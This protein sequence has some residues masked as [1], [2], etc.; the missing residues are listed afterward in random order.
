[1]SLRPDGSY[2][3]DKCDTDVDNGGV[4]AAVTIIGTD[5]DDPG[6]MRVPLHLCL[7]RDVDTNGNGQTEH[8]P[9]CRD[10]VLTARALAAYYEHVT[11]S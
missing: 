5:P 7:P 11:G 6:R 10:S 1:M 2:R 9:G 8:V 4:H 3:C